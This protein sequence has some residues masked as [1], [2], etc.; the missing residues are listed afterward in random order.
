MQAK[1][2]SLAE[3]KR[4]Y[5]DYLVKDFPADEVKPFSSIRRMTQKGLYQ[6][7]GFYE[8]ND[9]AAYA[10]LCD[11]CRQRFSLL[12]YYAVNASLRGRG[13]GQRALAVLR[14]RYR[15]YK[16]VIIES[17][18]PDF[19]KN[20][21]D[22]RTR[23]RRLAFYEKCGLT[24]SGVRG[25]AFGVEYRILYAPCSGPATNK[26]VKAALAEIYRMLVPGD[27]YKKFIRIRLQERG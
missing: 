15:A 7:W 3:C 25:S 14:E 8:E 21:E 5:E 11:D 20:E 22:R 12:D 1:L 6:S 17:E 2:L 9:L 23:V 27:A 13:Y 26:E 4:V 18:N 19:A 16:G 10:F 24:D